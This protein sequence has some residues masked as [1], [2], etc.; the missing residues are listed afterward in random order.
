MKEGDLVR[1]R[2]GKIEPDEAGTVGLLLELHP[3]SF[4]MRGWDMV[5]VLYS[6]GMRVFNKG[7]IEVVNESR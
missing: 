3:K 1:K 5:T 4:D 7:N 2:W 6:F